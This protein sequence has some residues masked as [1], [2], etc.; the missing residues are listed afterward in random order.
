MVPVIIPAYKNRKQLRKCI[1]HLERQTTPCDIWVK[2]NSVNNDYFTGA[3]NKGLK[4]FLFEQCTYI[5]IIDQDMY[6]APDAV[7]WMVR[8]M[9]SHPLCGIGTP[10]VKLKN[11]GQKVISGG[12]SVMYPF[13][14]YMYLENGGQFDDAPLFWAESTC[15][16]LRKEMLIEIGLLD[17]NYRVVFMDSDYCLTAR[18]RG[19]QVWRISNAI[20]E[21]EK[22]NSL[23]K[24]FM[25]EEKRL[26]LAYFE[27]KWVNSS[28][29]NLFTILNYKQNEMPSIIGN[30]SNAQRLQ[31]PK[32]DIFTNDILHHLSFLRQICF[33]TNAKLILELGVRTGNSTRAFLSAIESLKGRLISIDIED[34]SGVSDSPYWEFHQMNDLDFDTNNDEFDIIF[35]DTS[36]TYDQTLA[37]LRK[38][39]PKLKSGGAILL[40]DTISFQ[41]VLQAIQTYL[42]ENPDRYE[43]ENRK[44]SN[45]LGVLRERENVGIRNS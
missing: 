20:G 37:E 42:K 34:C 44:S 9:N 27:A 26:D 30:Y 41:P 8:F 29:H 31:S 19:W 23:N 38:F 16:I 5:I 24:D 7:G 28:R 12:G 15:W 14:H 36:H 25:A 3:V 1:A 6:L 35:I 13:G 39:A 32:C 40:H 43:F 45:G 4:H 33:D 22:S 2:D 11:D 21:H 10:L 18:S 17:P